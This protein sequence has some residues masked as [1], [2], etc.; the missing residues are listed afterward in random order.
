MNQHSRQHHVIDAIF[1][2]AIFFVFTA[3]LL[4]VLLLAA[5]IYSKTTI[6]SDKHFTD[7]TAFAYVME[8]VRQNDTDGAL[9]VQTIDGTDCLTLTTSTDT[10]TTITYIYVN[11]GAL[12][13]LHVRE[14]INVSLTDGSEISELESMSISEV[15]P[16][17]YEILM[18]ATDGTSMKLTMAER[19]GS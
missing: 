2:I 14:G 9:S 1:P 11:D 15:S 6:E 12:R 5:R 10:G 3:S 13:E 7:R 8:K 16:N 19:S 17:L 18:T 4:I